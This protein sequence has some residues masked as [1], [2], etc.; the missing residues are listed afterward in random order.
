MKVQTREDIYT[1][2]L[3]TWKQ[4]TLELSASEVDP[5]GVGEGAEWCDGTSMTKKWV[6]QQ[7]SSLTGVVIR[8]TMSSSAV[9][10]VPYVGY[11]AL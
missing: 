6:G 11:E 3:N 2:G 5:T 7:H 9:F 4:S 10:L 8:D 1:Q